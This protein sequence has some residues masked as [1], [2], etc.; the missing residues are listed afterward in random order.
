MVACGSLILC[1]QYVSI[2]RWLNKDIGKKNSVPKSHNVVF[3]SQNI[4]SFFSPFKIWTLK[5][6][7]GAFYFIAVVGVVPEVILPLSYTL[8]PS[9]LGSAKV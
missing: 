1:A 8:S 9:R 3:L 5:D 4:A 7:S 2:V 6:P